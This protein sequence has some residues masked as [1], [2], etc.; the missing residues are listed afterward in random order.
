M[1]HQVPAV[2]IYGEPQPQDDVAENI[3]GFRIRSAD[4]VVGELDGVLRVR[5]LGGVEAAVD[6]DDRFAFAGQGVG[7][8]VGEAAGPGQLARDESSQDRKSTRLNS[9]HT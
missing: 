3:G 5:D 2:G 1:H 8:F 6:V 4:Q 9:S 7:A